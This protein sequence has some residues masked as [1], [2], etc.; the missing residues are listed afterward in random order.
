MNP[1]RVYVETNADK[2]FAE[3]LLRPYCVEVLSRFYTSAAVIA[4]E[5]SLLNHPERPV[6]VVLKPEHPGDTPRQVQEFREC[7]KRI[8]ARA[9]YENWY[10]AIADPRL[11]AWARTDPRI[12]KD[13]EA[14]KDGKATYTELAE[15]FVELTRVQPFD[16]TELLRTN[17]DFRGLVEF[18]QRHAPTEARSSVG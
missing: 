15:R 3:V 8:L 9:H 12:R 11:D 5:T 16:P 4:A 10:V 7:A 6:A 2:L 13:L 1:L 17:A 18:L 14:Y